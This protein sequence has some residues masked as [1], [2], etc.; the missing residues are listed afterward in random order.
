M[1]RSYLRSSSRAGGKRPIATRRLPPPQTFSTKYVK[2]KVNLN[3]LC[4]LELALCL[5]KGMFYA[6]AYAKGANRNPTGQSQPKARFFEGGHNT[7]YCVAHKKRA[8]GKVL[9]P[10]SLQAA[11][12]GV[13]R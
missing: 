13:A 1:P 7:A 6:T 4:K 12:Y 5:R 9:E 2:P 11:S 10:A 3:M 8:T